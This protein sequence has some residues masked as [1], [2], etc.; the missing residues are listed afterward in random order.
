MEELP[1]YKLDPCIRALELCFNGIK[2]EKEGSVSSKLVYH[3]TEL[4]QTFQRLHSSNISHRIS[5]YTLATI[6]PAISTY[7]PLPHKA[8]QVLHSQGTEALS[9][10]SIQTFN[11][12]K[13]GVTHA[14]VISPSLLAP[15]V[16]PNL[17]LTRS[18]RSATLCLEQTPG[19]WDRGSEIPR[20]ACSFMPC[21][22]HSGRGGSVLDS[23]LRRGPCR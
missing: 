15:C 22:S 16:T 14:L 23:E 1:L 9:E 2:G 10:N 7:R 3:C 19:R 11:S 6:H 8:N 18:R 20:L 13:P 21:W 17:S 12:V 5:R 4:I